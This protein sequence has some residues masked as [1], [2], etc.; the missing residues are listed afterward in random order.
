MLEKRVARVGADGTASIG[1]K[2]KRNGEERRRQWQENKK[3][4]SNGRVIVRSKVSLR[5][6]MAVKKREMAS[7]TRLEPMNKG[8]G[9]QKARDGTRPRA[10][11]C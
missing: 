11:P 5:N 8:R 10:K 9:K 4:H 7:Q 2:D 6:T 1:E 3:V